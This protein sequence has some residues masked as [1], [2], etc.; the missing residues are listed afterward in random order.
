V[1]ARLVRRTRPYRNQRIIAVIHD[2]FFTGGVSSFAERFGS[3][4][5]KYRGPDEPP[6][7][8]MPMSMVA[9]VA[10]GVRTVPPCKCV[11]VI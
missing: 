1:N 7:R 10:T 11:Q 4:F 6:T 8:E 5:P 3:L 2:L 9:L